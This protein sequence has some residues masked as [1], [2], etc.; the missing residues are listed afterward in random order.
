MYHLVRTKATLLVVAVG[1]ALALSSRAGAA[2]PAQRPNV[3]ILL[4]DDLGY[5]DVGFQGGKDIPTPHIDALAKSGVRC[6]SGYVSGPYCS[7][8][9]AG[10]MTGRYQQRFGHEF[11]PVRPGVG[12]S[13]QGLATTETTLAD[14]LKGAGYATGLVGKWHLGEEEQFHPLNRGFGE[15]FGFLAGSHSYVLPDD[16]VQGPILRG[17]ERVPLNGYLTDVLARE[18]CAFIDRHQKE[19]F[20]LYLAFNAVHTPLQAP[21]PAVKP[22]AHIADPNRRTYLAMTAALDEAIGTVLAKLHAAGLDENTLVF[23]LSDNGGPVGK[24][25]A[26]GA[27]NDPL[28][29]SKGDTWEGGIRV[30]FVVRWTGR[31]PVGKT[32]DRPVI[33]LDIHATAQAAGGVAAD[34]ARK[35]DGV[36]LLPFLGGTNHSAPHDALYWRF[37]PQ[38]AVRQGDWKLVRPDRSTSAPFG[39]VAKEPMLFNL[40]DD[41]G[42][43]HDLAAAQ[44]GRVRDLQA[45]WDKWNAELAAPRWP[46]TAGG[47]AIQI[48]P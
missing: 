33:P 21:E 10:L 32:Y 23:F 45:A 9:R 48:R 35:P 8:T 41:I 46:A 31:L 11:N 14:R 16:P 6:T 13:G 1:L 15:Y 29:G 3:V 43:R 47:R 19:P 18:A 40:A 28:R 7:P 25:S 27:R 20:F 4:A 17:R 2:E 26:N 37:G 12:G 39:D 5:A 22:L 44:P 24:F 42:E 34:P 36:N 30:P 38:M